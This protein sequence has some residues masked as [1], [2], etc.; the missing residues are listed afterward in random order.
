MNDESKFDRLF[1]GN[2]KLKDKKPDICPFAEEFSKWADELC[3]GI[4]DLDIVDINQAKLQLLDK[5]FSWVQSVSKSH[6][7]RVNPKG[8][9]CIYHVF[10]DTY[11]KLRKI[12]LS[13]HPPALLPQ[14]LTGIPQ[15]QIAGIFIGE[16]EEEN[17]TN[18]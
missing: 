11:F 1:G 16:K 5:Y 10:S 8:H 7:Y 6:R 3:S 17:E 15:P 12:E 18:S 2:F 13:L 14:H 4:D 9:I